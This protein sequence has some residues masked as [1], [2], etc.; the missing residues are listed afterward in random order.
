VINKECITAFNFRRKVVLRSGGEYFGDLDNTVVKEAVTKEGR[1][2]LLS[3][4]SL[5]NS[6]NILSAYR[7]LC[8]LLATLRTGTHVPTL[9]HNTV[10]RRVHADFAQ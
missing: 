2:Q 7:T 6:Y 3:F 10:N 4:E 8:H 9:Q 1:G 5:D